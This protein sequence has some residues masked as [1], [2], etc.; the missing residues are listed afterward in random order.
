M[1]KYVLVALTMYTW[2]ELEKIGKKWFLSFKGFRNMML[3]DSSKSI[4]NI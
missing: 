2:Q 3:M 1:N 4:S